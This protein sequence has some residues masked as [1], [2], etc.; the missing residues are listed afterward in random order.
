MNRLVENL[1]D[2]KIWGCAV[3][4]ARADLKSAVLRNVWVRVPPAL[5]NIMNINDRVKIT[6]ILNEK[7][8]ADL[9]GRVEKYSPC[10]VGQTGTVVFI[11]NTGDIIN[12]VVDD[13][14]TLVLH[15]SE[16]SL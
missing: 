14:T 11:G 6:N 4:V 10:L 8:A 12:V 7:D 9:V 5:P 2:I 13:V 15:V 16:V 1:G 3:M